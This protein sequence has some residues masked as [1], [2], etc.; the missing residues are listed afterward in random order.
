[1]ILPRLESFAAPAIT[2]A[3]KAPK[4]FLALYDRAAERGDPFEERLKLA[5]KGIL[6]SPDFLFRLER[7][8]TTVA[9]K[10][11]PGHELA[12]RLSYFL[13]SSMPDD[14]LLG[15]VMSLLELTRLLKPE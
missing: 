12:S 10:P 13:W 1:M 2:K 5:I 8:A 7:P 4:R 9:A 6:V 14:E 3:A 15:R 11:L